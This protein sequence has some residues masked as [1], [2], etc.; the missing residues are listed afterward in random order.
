LPELSGTRNAF[1]I[2]EPFK[3]THALT[4]GTVY[5]IAFTKTTQTDPKAPPAP[6]THQ[7]A[8]YTSLDGLS[9]IPVPTFCRLH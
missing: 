6:A 7:L 8:L 9:I 2:Q 3:Y 1:K 5:Q 4:L